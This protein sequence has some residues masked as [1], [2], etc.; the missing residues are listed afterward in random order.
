MTTLIL[1]VVVLTA[2]VVGYIAGRYLPIHR[3]EWTKW[4]F[5]GATTV[6]DEYN[7]PI[8]KEAKFM[9]ECKTCGRVKTRKEKL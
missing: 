3:H 7:D 9:R 8:R 4:K 6:V 1:A 2:L 5:I